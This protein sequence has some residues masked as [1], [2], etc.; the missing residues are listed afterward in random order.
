[1]PA[2]ESLVLKLVILSAERGLLTHDFWLRVKRAN[3]SA[4]MSLA[5][6]MAFST[7]PAALT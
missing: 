6:P 7:P 1:M 4:P 2:S 5:K 3:A